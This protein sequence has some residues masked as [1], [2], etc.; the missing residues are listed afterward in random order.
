[1]FIVSQG[2][3]AQINVIPLGVVQISVA[4]I[5]S[6]IHALRLPGPDSGQSTSSTPYLCKIPSTFFLFLN[7]LT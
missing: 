7:V 5:K 2:Y 6:Y 1:M 3:Y 4:P